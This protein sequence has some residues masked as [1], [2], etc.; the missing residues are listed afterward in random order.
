MASPETP[1]SIDLSDSSP[2]VSSE[3]APGY[4]TYGGI[5]SPVFVEDEAPPSTGKMVID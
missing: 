2:L 4:R 3:V 1:E 5:D